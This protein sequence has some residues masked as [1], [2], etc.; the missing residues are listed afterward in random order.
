MAKHGI[1]Y[2]GSKSKL[3]ERIVDLLP[4]ATHLYD[5]FAGG[6]AVTHCALQSGKWQTVHF[7]DI[8]DSVVLFKNC[9]EGNIPDGSEWIS[10]EEFYKR[11]DS[12]PYVRLIW[13]FSNNQR[14]YLY[15]R[16]IE[17]YKKAVHEMIYAKTPR[18]RRLKFKEVCR[19]MPTVTE[20]QS[21]DHESSERAAALNSLKMGGV[22][23]APITISVRETIHRLQHNERAEGGAM[24]M[25]PFLGGE[26]EMSMKDYRDVEMLPDSVIYC[27]I[28]YRNTRE[29][30]NDTFC[31]ED[32]YEWALKQTT[33]LFISEY[34]MPE[35]D[36]VCVA[37]FERVSTFSAT[38]NSLRKV[39]CIFR[40]RW[41]VDAK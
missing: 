12:D 7:N 15:S 35:P 16:R 19:L 4:S 14:D 8:S 36:F 6:C 41:Q 18:E 9:L 22:Q 25:P 10:R 20:R 5:L 39:E 29:Y 31:H 28:P 40:P 38:N 37:E 11:K 26:Y 23:P 3:A 21:K 34:S 13:S 17:P 1:P 32:F 2:Q 30:R 24:S 33:P 27:D